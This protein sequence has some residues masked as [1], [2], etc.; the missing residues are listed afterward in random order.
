MTYKAV[1]VAHWIIGEATRQ[2]LKITPMQL[3]KILY[4]CQGW[5][6]GMTGKPLFDDPVQAWQHGPVVHSVYDL[7]RRFGR[8]PIAPN[9]SE[10][11]AEI[12]GLI[13]H[14][15]KEK[16]SFSAYTLREMTHNETPYLSTPRNGEITQDVMKDFFEKTFYDVDEEDIY[17]PEYPTEDEAMK[18]TAEQF[19]EEELD[20]LISAL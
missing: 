17:T 6:L 15:V 18:A 19:S 7:Y 5:Q 13:R 14:C 12:A 3:Q 11:P 4:Y 2:G 8:Y 10:A 20:E 16:G 9:T 1:Q